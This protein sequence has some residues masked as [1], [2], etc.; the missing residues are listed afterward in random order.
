MKPKKVIQRARELRVQQTHAEQLLWAALRRH[1]LGGL[2]FR[3][4]H[5]VGPYFADFACV[6][7]RLIIE[8]DGG[9]HDVVAI[10]DLQR[11][12]SLEDDGWTVL[13]FSNDDVT[14]DVESVVHSVAQL[15]G[16]EYQPERRQRR[17]SSSLIR[18]QR[19]SRKQRRSPPPA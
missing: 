11:Q 7:H 4:Q 3:R 9:Y 6:S 15:L 18:R 5:P 17:E 2:K 19:K 12:R 13:R 10:H 1:N 16:I 14:T 8:V